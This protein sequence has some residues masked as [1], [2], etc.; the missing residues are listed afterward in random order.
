MLANQK[1]CLNSICLSPWD[2]REIRLFASQIEGHVQVF[3][4]WSLLISNPGKVLEEKA[5]E[6]LS[7]SWL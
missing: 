2:N 5:A 4:I 7:L 3:G 6:K 1:G